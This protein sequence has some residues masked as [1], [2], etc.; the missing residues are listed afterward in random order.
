MYY[1]E[2]KSDLLIDLITKKYLIAPFIY[3]EKI[4]L[5]LEYIYI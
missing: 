5:R 4:G 3:Y 1:F 2:S